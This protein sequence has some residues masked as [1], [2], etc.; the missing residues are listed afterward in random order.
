[1][2]DFSV[3]DVRWFFFL[4]S[5]R[6]TKATFSTFIRFRAI[7]LFYITL[8]ILVHIISSQMRT[9]MH[10]LSYVLFSFFITILLTAFVQN[11]DYSSVLGNLDCCLDCF[12]LVCR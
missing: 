6:L 2:F 5:L 4:V 11:S 7:F 10:Y 12:V 8:R 9:R 1:M 3:F